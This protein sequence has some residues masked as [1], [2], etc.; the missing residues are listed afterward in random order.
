[1]LRYAAYACLVLAI[2]RSALGAG[3]SAVQ[4][5]DGAASAL[6]A[7]A[8]WSFQMERRAAGPGAGAAIDLDTRATILRV[9]DEAH[10]GAHFDI[11]GSYTLATSPAP[12]PLLLRYDGARALSIRER[13][14]VVIAGDPANMGLALL[15]IGYDA[16]LFDAVIDPNTLRAGAD[17]AE[18]LPQR[19]VSGEPCDV[20]FIPGAGDAP[21]ATWYFGAEDRLP[22]RID[23]VAGH[24]A[25]AYAVTTTV[26]GMEPASGL[27]GLEDLSDWTRK[28]FDPARLPAVGDPAADLAVTTPD[29]RTLTLA[30]QRGKVVVVKFWAT[31]CGACLAGLP[32]IGDLDRRYADDP[33]VTV[34]GV[35]CWDEGEID[36][37]LTR[38]GCRFPSGVAPAEQIDAFGVTAL[39]IVLV[40]DP[41]GRI[42]HAQ[43]GYRPDAERELAAAIDGL[44]GSD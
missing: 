27:P 17:R 11:R 25:D 44:L 26:S 42:A 32:G 34:M 33:R 14:G 40:I 7:E 15:G 38:A 24:G 31:W 9:P 21:G 16:P 1:M 29:G 18:A 5:L 36:A 19:T 3:P 13:G 22:R 20:V 37:A 12:D 39:P 6:E 4:V 43:L 2:G 28:A 30:E 35:N 8:G 41:E 10:L 23:L